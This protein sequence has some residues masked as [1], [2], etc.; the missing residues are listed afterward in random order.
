MEASGK[1][2]SLF[3][4]RDDKE[5]FR[6]DVEESNTIPLEESGVGLDTQSAFGIL[7]EVEYGN[8]EESS[9]PS[10]GEEHMFFYHIRKA[11]STP[12]KLGRLTRSKTKPSITSVEGKN[13]KMSPPSRERGRP[14]GQGRWR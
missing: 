5:D 13:M 1:E 11:I 6:L 8:S 10:K 7:A 4:N 14:K 9:I 12:E 3:V 2:L